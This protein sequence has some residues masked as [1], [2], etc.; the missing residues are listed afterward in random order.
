MKKPTSHDALMDCDGSQPVSWQLA[1]RACEYAEIGEG[2]LELKC[3]ILLSLTLVYVRVQ[4]LVQGRWEGL[5]F[6]GAVGCGHSCYGR[7]NI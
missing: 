1:R 2:K 3:S 4:L 7:F 6:L 5:S